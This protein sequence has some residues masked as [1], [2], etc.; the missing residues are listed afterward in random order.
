MKSAYVPLTLSF[1][2]SSDSIV[3]VWV[4]E[5]LCMHVYTVYFYLCEK[6]NQKLNHL[7]K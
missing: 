1:V 5:D 7:W 6:R 4:N 2:F 3:V